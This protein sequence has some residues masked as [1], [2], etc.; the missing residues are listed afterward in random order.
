M[1]YFLISYIASCKVVGKYYTL[2]RFLINFT[3][4]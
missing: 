2:V 3:D 1:I 4:I